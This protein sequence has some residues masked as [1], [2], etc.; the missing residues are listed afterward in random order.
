MRSHP[1]TVALWQIFVLVVL[2]FL[3]FGL[4]G[5]FSI[6]HGDI[7]AFLQET[8]R[9]NSRRDAFYD[10]NRVS[11]FFWVVH[12][13]LTMTAVASARFRR[14]DVFAV[15]LIGPV[16]GLVISLLW[17]R[18]GDPN[19]TVFVGVCLFGWLVGTIVGGVYWFMTLNHHRLEAGGF[20]S[21]MQARLKEDRSQTG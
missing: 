14:S 5:L 15:L 19:W 6:A 18:W 10:L 3:W 4:I 11:V 13:F 21:R 2:F 17:Q 16:I 20:D 8:F 9:H 12:S 1:R 7:E